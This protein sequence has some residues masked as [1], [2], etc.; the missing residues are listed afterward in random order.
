M[1]SVVSVRLHGVLNLLFVRARH[2]FV[3]IFEKNSNIKR[4]IRIL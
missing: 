4:Y 3:R 2:I 1:R